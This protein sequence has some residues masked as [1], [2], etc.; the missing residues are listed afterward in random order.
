MGEIPNACGMFTAQRWFTCRLH[1]LKYCLTLTRWLAFILLPG[2]RGGR[3][4]FK[5][6]LTVCGVPSVP[7]QQEEH[8][9]TDDSLGQRPKSQAL[10]RSSLQRG[11]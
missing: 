9:R 2:T 11:C 7:Q 6:H 5:E 8:G 1:E 4:L 10:G 3:R